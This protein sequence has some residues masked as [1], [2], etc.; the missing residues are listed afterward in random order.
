MRVLFVLP[1]PVR[2][3]SGGPAVVY[4]HAKELARRGHDVTVA[5]PRR[6]SGVKG[7]LRGTVGHIR[8]RI[9]GVPDQPLHDVEGVTTIEVASPGHLDGRGYDSVIATGHQTAPWVHRAL[10]EGRAGGVYFI[11]GD[12]RYQSAA[13][14]HSWALPF[15]RVT[16]SQWLADELAALGHSVEA[17][18]PNAV[19]PSVFRQTRPLSERGSRVVALYHRAPVKGPD[20]LIKALKLLKVTHPLVEADVISARPP[21][22]RFPAWVTVHV[23]PSQP[24]LVEL[25]NRAAVCLHTS[26]LEGWG[27]V[28]M[29]SAACGCAVVATASRGVAEFLTPGES[30]VQVQPGDAEAIAYEAAALLDAPE[31]RIRLARAGRKSVTRY[32]WS[33]STDRLEAV[34]LSAV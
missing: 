26:R 13:A 2:V 19:D 29:E 18:I 10:G 27:L 22:H 34:L 30:M 21:E 24:D 17:V 20:T 14:A 12:E 33:E 6:M 3:P 23:R 25:Y 31:Q 32:S 28:A 4:T 16:V 7:G 5:A 8:N 11:Q 15:T 9:H 1:A